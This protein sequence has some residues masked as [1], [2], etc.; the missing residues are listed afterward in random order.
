MRAKLLAEL[1]FDFLTCPNGNPRVLVR[2]VE[3]KVRRLGAYVISLT[4]HNSDAINARAEDT[5]RFPVSK[6]SPKISVTFR[7]TLRILSQYS[8]RSV[9][10]RKA[11]EMRASSSLSG[12]RW[13]VA[14]RFVRK[15]KRCSMR[16]LN[17][18]RTVATVFATGSTCDIMKRVLTTSNDSWP[19]IS[20][21]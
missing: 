11:Q 16:V 9:S 13:S 18:Q 10:R 3:F 7:P 21:H 5:K 14:Q 6:A 8:A 17:T 19:A 4:N 1:L 15:C 2:I 20:P 12:S